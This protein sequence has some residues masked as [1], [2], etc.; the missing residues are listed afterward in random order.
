MDQ[1]WD[2]GRAAVV[3]AEELRYRPDSGSGRYEC[4]GCGCP[5]TAAA[6][7]SERVRPYFRAGKEHPHLRGC[8]IAG[9]PTLVRSDGPL[10][11]ARTERAAGTRYPCRLVRA[12]AHE[13]V[14]PTA[15]DDPE[16]QSSRSDSRSGESGGNEQLREA[17]AAT[18]RPFCRT[19]IRYPDS[20]VDLRI[21]IPGIDAEYYQY[22]FRRLDFDKIV[23]YPR[24]RIFYAEVAW[25]TAP[26]FTDA[27]AVV[28][29]YAGERDP[30]L[31]ARVLRPYRV[32]IDWSGWNQRLR[33]ALRRE[34]AS[35]RREAR[36][37]SGSDAKS[38][39]F[40]LSE[41]NRDDPEVF[42]LDH[43]SDYAFVT[44]HLSYPVK[45][46]EAARSSSSSPVSSRFRKSTR[47]RRGPLRH[48]D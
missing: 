12:T 10:E 16:R 25:S 39:F 46:P 7:D 21:Q 36:E 24:S 30:Q 45:K 6:L 9:D 38:W 3:D 37:H 32:I 33:S 43:Y 41:P 4:V 42:R 18:I 44:A 28:S 47:R 27:A 40:F 19:F 17:T 20:R 29:L 15:T 22:A 11:P 35:A 2:V 23:V 13:L 48:V 14:D 1:A 26:E 5:A 34:I 8:P 31:R